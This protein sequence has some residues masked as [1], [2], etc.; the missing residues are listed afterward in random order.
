MRGTVDG[1]PTPHPLGEQLPAVFAD[2]SFTQRFVAA[3]DEVLA[4]VFATLDNQAAYLD[5]ALAPDDYVDW[6]AKWVALDVEEQWPLP[7]R[8]RLVSTAVALHRRRGTRGGLAGLIE[9]VT[10][11]RAEVLDSGGC[12]ASADPGTPLP[13]ADR[14]GLLVRVRIPDPST[15]DAARLDALVAANKPAH[16]PHT[17]EILAEKDPR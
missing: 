10:G 16:L 11:G 14:P 6:L 1:L 17:L 5:P 9:L 3:L 13:G 12:V 15:V 7:R 8:R 4:P 2:D